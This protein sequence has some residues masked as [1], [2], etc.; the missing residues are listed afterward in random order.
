MRETPEGRC[1]PLRRPSYVTRGKSK[2]TVLL[3][4]DGICFPEPRRYLIQAVAGGRQ[5][6]YLNDLVSLVASA[7]H[8]QFIQVFP[9][10]LAM[11]APLPWSFMSEAD[12]PVIVW[13]KYWK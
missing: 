5:Q 2:A 1:K 13:I 10:A 6:E 11:P 12:Y 7:T 3:I 8:F 9:G 4:E